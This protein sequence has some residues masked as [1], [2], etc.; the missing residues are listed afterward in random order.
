M[1]IF[2]I[3]VFVIAIVIIISSF[4]MLLPLF[5]TIVFYLCIYRIFLNFKQMTWPNIV[6]SWQ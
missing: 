1:I 6:K 2:A 4:S 3:I 5:F